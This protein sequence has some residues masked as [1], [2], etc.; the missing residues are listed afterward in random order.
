MQAGSV[1][2]K[3]GLCIKKKPGSL[4]FFRGSREL[5]FAIAKVC[6]LPELGNSFNEIYKSEVQGV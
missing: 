1:Y 6:N 2:N 5:Y 4:N 3:L